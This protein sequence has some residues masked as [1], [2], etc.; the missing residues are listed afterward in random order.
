[1]ALSFFNRTQDD[2]TW[3]LARL[4]RPWP[5]DRIPILEF[6]RNSAALNHES[7]S[8]LPDEEWLTDMRSIKFAPGVFDRMMRVND[9]PEEAYAQAN[10][11]VHAV[12]GLTANASDRGLARLYAAITRRRMSEVLQL[13]DAVLRETP[14]SRPE[15]ARAIGMLLLRESP[16]R[17]PVKV[18]MLLL[19][20]T[21]MDRADAE[22]VLAIGS[23]GEF[24]RF[25]VDALR[26]R[27]DG[28]QRIA[29]EMAKRATGPGRSAAVVALEGATDPQIRQWLLGEGWRDSDYDESAAFCCAT[30]GGLDEALREGTVSLEAAGG[31]LQSLARAG[32]FR[33]RGLRELPN[34][35]RIT[36][37][38]CER[39]ERTAPAT[40]Q[41]DVAR[42]LHLFVASKHAEWPPDSE[43]TA[44][45]RTRI[46]SLCAARLRLP[47]WEEIVWR[48]IQNTDESARRHAYVVAHL[49]HMD[50][51]DHWW[52]LAQSNP[53]FTEWP[54]LTFGLTDSRI[55]AFLELASER[56]KPAAGE[57]FGGL[58]SIAMAMSRF[59]GKGW[60]FV[61]AAI[62]SRN[63]VYSTDGLRTMGEW[64]ARNWTAEMRSELE[65][66]AGFHSEAH[67]RE[68]AGEIL[69]GEWHRRQ[70]IEFDEEPEVWES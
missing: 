22:D 57:E 21:E 7:N 31:L 2:G 67:I 6:L 53:A 14:F 70:R 56:L 1:M 51:W 37:D 43:W 63:G 41:F 47:G 46:A 15:R 58:G 26:G 52:G 29:W 64:E 30:T 65:R 32:M 35:S 50:L 48:E 60:E 34:G 19:G 49:R 39:V 18:G 10:A 68:F 16:D 62:W 36:L 11:V 12:H 38:Y 27:V 59:P 40:W 23:H 61:K 17:D 69:R 4:V 13:I 54:R 3:S 42:S 8:E 24:S 66:A 45:V 44:E 20:K 25:A 5:K 9:T 33:E 28:W 55:D